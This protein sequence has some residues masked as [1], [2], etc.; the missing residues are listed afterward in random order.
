MRAERP[1]CTRLRCW[2][3]VLLDEPVEVVPSDQPWHRGT[4]S[5]G[6]RQTFGL[7]ASDA[8]VV[9]GVVRGGG[10]KHDGRETAGETSMDRLGRAEPRARDVGRADRGT[11][12]RDR[13]GIRV[14]D[15]AGRLLT[16]IQPP[17]TA[18][19]DRVA[20]PAR[21]PARR[22]RPTPRLQAGGALLAVWWSTATV[23]DPGARTRD[24]HRDLGAL[25]P[26]A[27]AVRRSCADTASRR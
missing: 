15:R 21:G 22:S 17:A 23:T 6:D 4:W 20:T 1:A 14:G 3:D 7:G 13:E 25:D 16:A 9:R 5:D 10:L 12:Q 19:L 26:P 8:C 11:P 18:P 2:Y 24:P 27:P